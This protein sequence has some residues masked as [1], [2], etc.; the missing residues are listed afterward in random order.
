M[1]LIEFSQ[2]EAFS[3]RVND[4]DEDQIQS[5][6]DRFSGEQPFVMAYLMAI[7]FDELAE[8]E[9]ELLFYLGFKVWYTYAET[10]NKL[11]QVDGETLE[12]AE[13]D[14]DDM[15]H[16]LSEESEE[17]FQEFAEQMMENH[18]QGDLLQ[19]V[20][21]GLLE[22]EEEPDENVVYADN[23]GL[24]FIALKTVIDS[25]QKIAPA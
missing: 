16:Y 5:L 13:M 23:L 8:E 2:I 14:N 11:A 17:G 18:P 1:S 22:D 19:F 3:E 10:R 25:F 6:I 21:I 9:R 24:M 4:L 7:H 20:L 12:S 15:L